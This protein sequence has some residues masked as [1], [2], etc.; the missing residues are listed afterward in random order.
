MQQS[1]TSTNEWPDGTDLLKVY[2]QLRKVDV[3]R[4]TAHSALY[5]TRLKCRYNTESYCWPW[6]TFKAQHFIW[7]GIYSCICTKPTSQQ[8]SPELSF[9]IIST[10][11]NGPFSAAQPTTTSTGHR[12]RISHSIVDIQQS[13]DGNI[14]INC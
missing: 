11:S 9:N 6:Q 5:A 8:H 14:S 2:C 7:F 10:S 3:E 12:L 13:I 4:S 1:T